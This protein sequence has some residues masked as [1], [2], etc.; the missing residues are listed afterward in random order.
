MKK[1]KR[2]DYDDEKKYILKDFKDVITHIE[3]IHLA[4][5]NLLAGF[6]SC[7]PLD[8]YE[9]KI[10]DFNSCIKKLDAI[11]TKI[12]EF[13]LP[14][15]EYLEEESVKYCKKIGVSKYLTYNQIILIEP[16]LKKMGKVSDAYKENITLNDEELLNL[17]SSIHQYKFLLFSS[18]TKLKKFIEEIKTETKQEVV[19]D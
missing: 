5:M 4:E 10:K 13:M 11:N 14:L 7:E 6:G 19:N 3:G 2:Y 9:E 17:R 1:L 12:L 18:L 15:K 8:T 16:I